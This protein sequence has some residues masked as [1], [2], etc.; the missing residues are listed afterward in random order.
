[1]PQNSLLSPASL[2]RAHFYILESV[3]DTSIRFPSGYDL[4]NGF[5]I[6]QYLPDQGINIG[7]H[8]KC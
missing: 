3:L 1:M 7:I 5:K 4:K 2:G 8:E 6:C